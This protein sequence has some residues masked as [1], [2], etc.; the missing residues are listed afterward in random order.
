MSA[1]D[2]QG[3]A[4][5]TKASKDISQNDDDVIQIEVWKEL[6]GLEQQDSNVLKNLSRSAD[7]YVD[8]SI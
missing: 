6:K 8:S 2:K 3:G 1:H 7:L 5:N 4:S